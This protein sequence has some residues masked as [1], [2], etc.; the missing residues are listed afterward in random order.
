MLKFKHMLIE[1]L[2]IILFVCAPDIFAGLA[3]LIIPRII[4]RNVRNRCNTQV[5]AHCIR[6]DDNSTP[7]FQ[8]TYL[9]DEREIKAKSKMDIKA[10]E[11]RVIMINPNNVNEYFLDGEKSIAV[12]VCSVIG[13]IVLFV[14]TIM[15]VTFTS[16]AFLEA[17]DAFSN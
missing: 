14:P 17:R 8:Y 9:G 5:T 12:V 7:V 3:F 4:A 13:V 2:P 15:L 1:A 16:F 11:Q 10:G 6:Y